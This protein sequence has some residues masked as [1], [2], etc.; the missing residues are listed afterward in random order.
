MVEYKYKRNDIIMMQQI[1]KKDYFSLVVIALVGVTMACGAVLSSAQSMAESATA[2]VTVGSACTLTATVNTAHSAEILAGTSRQDIGST[3]LN[4][5]CNDSGGF[6]IYAIGYSGGEYGNN[7]MINQGDNT[8]TFNTGTDTSGNSSWAMKLAQV[9]TGTYAATIDNSFNNY[10]VVPNEYIKVAHRNSATDAVSANPAVGTSVS[11]TYQSYIASTQIAGTYEGKVKFTMVHPATE[12]PGDVPITCAA[13]KICYSPNAN[14]VEGT[15]GQQSV[16]GDNTEAMLLA[17]N[18]S[19]KGY[20]FAGWSEDISAADHL[21]TATVYG[22]QE[23]ITT[24]SD[25]STNGLS[26][27]AV[28]IPSAGSIQNWSG[29]P[30][31]QQGS[32]T[33]LT[34]QRDNDTYAIA[35]LADGNCWM[36]E[37]LRLDNTAEHNSDGALAQGYGTSSIYG[38]FSGLADPQNTITGDYAANSLYYSGVQEGTATIDIGTTNYPG[39]RI[40]R[41]NNNNTSTRANNPTSNIAR[42]YS[43]GNY[44]NWPAAIADTTYYN[45]RDDRITTSICPSGWRLPSGGNSG[46]GV[47]SGGFAYLSSQIGGTGADSAKAWRAYPNN[48]LLSG[49]FFGSGMDS[50][51]RGERGHC[52]SSTVV[53]YMYVY[54]AQLQ[55]SSMYPGTLSSTKGTGYNIR[56]IKLSSV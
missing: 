12:L 34:D 1:V 41:Y 15:M 21:S 9:T 19:R 16:S 2:S 27:Y 28:W 39:T 18:F 43:Y 37:N 31:L 5:I 4:T 30:S 32:V 54:V 10:H 36:I 50:L 25:H 22:P 56:C 35:K 13:N 38:N 26:L 53:N 49:T 51:Y 17:T 29:C 20:G 8:I 55:S 40:P 3:T 42:M 24:K 44:Y 46:S 47:A 33:A 45:T 14:S 7:T 52:W 23:T 6:A 48:F 11:L